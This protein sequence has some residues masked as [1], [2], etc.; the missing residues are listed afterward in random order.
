[1]CRAAFAPVCRIESILM[2]LPCHHN[3]NIIV[4]A[5][6][7]AF[8]T[9]SHQDNLVQQ[10]RDSDKLDA[11]GKT[12]IRKRTQAIRTTDCQLRWPP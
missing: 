3:G 6:Q 4:L 2:V 5:C 12:M 11:Q 10:A 1:M 9:K 8:L 7:Y